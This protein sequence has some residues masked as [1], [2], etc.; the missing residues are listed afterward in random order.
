[1]S[2]SPTKRYVDEYGYEF[3]E[4]SDWWKEA[5]TA[6]PCFSALWWPGYSTE[7]IEDTI[8]GKPVVIQLW[9]G[10]CQKFL[11]SQEFPGGIG[12][13]VGVYRKIPGKLPPPSLD[14][15]PSKFADV[16]LGTASK[17]SDDNLWW[18][19]PELN[20][21]ID[22]ELIN[23]KINE[24]FFRAGPEKTYWL[25]KW[26][27]EASYEKYKKDQNEN[28]PWFSMNYKLKYRINGKTY[29]WS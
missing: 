15:L 16:V 27:N 13:E 17:L 26:M 28:V 8:D 22:F 10:W 4:T 3:N 1:M 2:G 6:L 5:C 11:N 29:E 24:T 14:F 23:P 25:N 20:T 21:E 18:A 12:A 9:I 19:Y 7:I